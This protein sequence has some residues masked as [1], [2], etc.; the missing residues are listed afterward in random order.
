[1]AIGALAKIYWAKWN[2]FSEPFLIEIFK[3]LKANLKQKCLSI[4]NQL[5]IFVLESV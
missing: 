3:K 4:N 2:K 5:Y 1:L